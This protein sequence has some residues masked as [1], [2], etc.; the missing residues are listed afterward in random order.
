MKGY[1]C[2]SDRLFRLFRLTLLQNGLDPHEYWLPA[3]QVIPYNNLNGPYV[4]DCSWIKALCP[5]ITLH[6]S[7]ESVMAA[8]PGVWFIFIYIKCKVLGHK[9]THLSVGLWLE[10]CHCQPQQY[11]KYWCNDDGC[12][13][14][15]VLTELFHVISCKA[16]DFSPAV[17]YF[18]VIRT[19]CIGIPSSINSCW[20]C[21]AC[22]SR[23][24][25]RK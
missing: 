14:G 8:P 17:V 18:I 7:A 19:S 12:Y 24:N 5:F 1:M 22:L 6:L 3:C 13:F 21:R 16:G 23:L 11:V 20:N 9:K 25:Q 10:Q 2:E 4:L 15:V